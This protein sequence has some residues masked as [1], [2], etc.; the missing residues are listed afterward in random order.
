[1]IFN[2]YGKALAVLAKKP[3][4]LWG[5][6]LLV[7]FVF[8][9]LSYLLGGPVLLIGVIAAYLLIAA[10]ANIFLKG[11]RGEEDLHVVDAFGTFKD[12][13]T[14]KRVV[15][16]LAW[17]DLWAFLWGLIPFAGIVFAVIKHYEY[18]FAPYI[19]MEEKDLAPT[20]VKE[21]SSELTKGYKSKMFWADVLFWVLAGVI[22]IIL[23]LFARIPYI[24]VLFGII[25]FVFE[26]CVVAFGGLFLGLVRAAFYDEITGAKNN[27]VYVD[28]PADPAP[29]MTETTTE[30]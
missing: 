23:G 5:I 24:G 17:A 7:N 12:F 9:P 2:I 22:A 3:F 10:M 8:I 19:V 26:I 13:K 25:L 4:R 11:Y 27:A 20:K 28:A 6:S 18:A 1:M 21:R 30:Q 15:C 16:S 29:E 14:G